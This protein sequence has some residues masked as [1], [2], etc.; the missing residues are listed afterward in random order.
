MKSAL[1]N[2]FMTLA[3]LLSGTSFADST[4]N[5]SNSPQAMKSNVALGRGIVT[6]TFYMQTGSYYATGGS[7]PTWDLRIT[8]CPPGTAQIAGPAGGADPQL[9][10]ATG[11]DKYGKNY[12]LYSCLCKLNQGNCP[13]GVYSTGNLGYTTYV[14]CKATT[15]I[16]NFYPASTFQNAVGG[17]GAVPDI[18]GNNIYLY[19]SG[20]YGQPGG[21]LNVIY[22]PGAIQK[23]IPGFTPAVSTYAV[24]YPRC[25]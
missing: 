18:T 11:Q 15:S 9:T 20:V 4:D 19:C 8:Q 14:Q 12:D 17:E 5:P 24:A 2:T 7:G 21:C 10:S 3:L 25:N 23:S 16:E 1:I 22:P 6:A 13:T